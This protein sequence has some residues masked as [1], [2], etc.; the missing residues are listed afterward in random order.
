MI[1]SDDN[2]FDNEYPPQNSDLQSWIDSFK[3][4]E[5]GEDE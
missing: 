5:E 2:N 4:G 1:C 3:S